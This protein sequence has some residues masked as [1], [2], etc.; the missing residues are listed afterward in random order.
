MLKR[1]L[2]LSFRIGSLLLFKISGKMF[3]ILQ[4]GLKTRH[5]DADRVFRWTG[6]FTTPVQALM[7]GPQAKNGASFSGL[8]PNAP[9]TRGKIVSMR[10]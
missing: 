3:D 7:M 8:E 2:S 1:V 9:A 10:V 6:S 5:G 4:L